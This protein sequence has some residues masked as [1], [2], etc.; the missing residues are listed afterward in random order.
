M[1]LAAARVGGIHA[2]N[3]CHAEFYENLMME[4]NIIRQAYTAGVE[5]LLFL[6]SGCTIEVQSRSYLGE[7]GI[8]RFEGTYGRT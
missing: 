8:V 4:C 1:D 7:D 3:T 6:G 2:N 5:Q